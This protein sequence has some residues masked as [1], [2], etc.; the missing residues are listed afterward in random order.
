MAKHETAPLTRP[1]LQVS[2]K[3]LAGALTGVTASGLVWAG[4]L[5]GLDLDPALAGV[6][7]TIAA[8]IGGYWKRDRAPV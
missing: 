1:W 5:V 8:A 6:L 2:P 7:V 3:V 4:A